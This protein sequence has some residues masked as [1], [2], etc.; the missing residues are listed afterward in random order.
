MTN[1]LKEPETFWATWGVITANILLI[2]GFKY[3]QRCPAVKL[4]NSLAFR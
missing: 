1:E 4:E 3:W 2:G